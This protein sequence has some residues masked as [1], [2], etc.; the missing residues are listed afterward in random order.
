MDFPWQTEA[1]TETGSEASPCPALRP[2]SAY[3]RKHLHARGFNKTP[4]LDGR[5]PGP[6]SPT[7][8]SLNWDLLAESIGGPIKREVQRLR[9]RRGRRE[10]H[11]RV[12]GRMLSQPSGALTRREA[13]RPRFFAA[14][15]ST[16]L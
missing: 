9:H 11:C 8:Q 1:R 12:V 4:P 15:E 10:C 7:A 5:A 14:C 3:A 6:K 13:A 16:S 2:I